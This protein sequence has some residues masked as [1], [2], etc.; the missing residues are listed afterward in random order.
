MDRCMRAA[1][2]RYPS[3]YDTPQMEESLDI[4]WSVVHDRMENAWNKQYGTVKRLLEGLQHVSVKRRVYNKAR[5]AQAAG[6]AQ[7][8][9]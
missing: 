3:V 4:A 1:A 2:E 6:K 7:R 9:G 8:A 5:A